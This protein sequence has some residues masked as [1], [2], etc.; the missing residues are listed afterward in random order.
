MA[1]LLGRDWQGQESGE[2][3]GDIN[4]AIKR[5]SPVEITIVPR[6]AALEPYLN[7]KEENLAKSSRGEMAAFVMQPK[8][9]FLDDVKDMGPTKIF[10]A[11]ELLDTPESKVALAHELLHGFEDVYASDDELDTIKSCYDKACRDEREF[12]C[13]YGALKGEFLTTMGEEF[14]SLHGDDGP[15]WVKSEHPEMYKLLSNLTGLDPVKNG[16]ITL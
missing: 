8:I 3:A 4:N 16:K 14:L 7:E 2:L 13:H 6:G 5:T 10:V 12:P 11:E 15:Q 1:E 9:Q